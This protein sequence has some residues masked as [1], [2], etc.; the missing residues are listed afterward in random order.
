MHFVIVIPPKQVAFQV[1]EKKAANAS[2]GQFSLLIFVKV[3][4]HY[5][6]EKNTE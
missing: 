6:Q 2:G 1:N 5:Q 4:A 3:Y